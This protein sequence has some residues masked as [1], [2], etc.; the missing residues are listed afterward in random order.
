VKFPRWFARFLPGYI[1]GVVGFH[2]TTYAQ[3]RHGVPALGWVVFTAT[4]LACSALLGLLRG[5]TRTD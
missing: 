4:C 3:H 5:P 2:I 1:G